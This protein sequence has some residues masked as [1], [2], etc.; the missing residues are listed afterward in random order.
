LPLHHLSTHLQ[1]HLVPSLREIVLRL[2]AEY[3]IPWV[4]PWRVRATLMPVNPLLDRTLSNANGNPDY[5]AVVKYWLG[6]PPA[7]LARALAAVPGT[8]E[9]VVHPGGVPDVT[10]PASVNL[11]PEA[12]QTETEY[13]ARCWP[14]IA[15]AAG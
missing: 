13:L 7:A 15:R 5:L 1:F 12:R 3:R 4:R 10:F 2:A 6:M 14:L 11:S 9:L 8:I